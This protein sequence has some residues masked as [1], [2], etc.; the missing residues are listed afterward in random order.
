MVQETWSLNLLTNKIIIPIILLL[1]SSCNTKDKMYRHNF[2]RMDTI[3]DVMFTF[4]GVVN[5]SGVWAQ[6]DSLLKDW[7]ERFSVTGSISEVRK[8]NERTEQAV[9]VSNDLAEMIRLARNYSDSLDGGFDITVLPLKKIWG[10]AEDSPEDMPLPSSVAIDSAMMFIDYR[11]VTLTSN[12]DTL[13]FGSSQ[14][15]IDVGGVAKG[16][17]LKK[18]ASL[19][20][21]NGIRNYLINGGGDI[22]AKG[23]K[24]DSSQWVIGIQHPRMSEKLT[25]TFKLE[26]GSVFTSGDYERFRDVPGRRIHHIFNPRTG[27]SATVNQSVTIYGSDPLRNKFLSTGLFALPADSIVR[28]VNRRPD[29]ECLVVDSGGKVHISDRWKGSCKMSQ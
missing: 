15:K 27:Y 14:I 11:Q 16:F 22:I 24:P 21:T 26:K 13:I 7:D 12:Q 8:V 5:E 10:L 29:I 20:E 25:A 23:C 1:I 18:I 6:I 4:S 19:L 17:A 28:Y 3:I 9:P 2:F